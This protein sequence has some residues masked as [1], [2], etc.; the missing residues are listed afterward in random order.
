MGTKL[1][2]ATAAVVLLFSFT[3]SA[4][5][6]ERT[7]SRTLF[8]QGV[9][10]L[11]DTRPADALRLFLKAY[12]L[13]PHWSTLINVAICHRALGRHADAANVF[14]QVLD[15]TGTTSVPPEERARV[16]RLLAEMD[17]R[18][19]IVTLRLDPAGPSFLDGRAVEREPLRLEPGSHVLT[20]TQPGYRPAR[21]AFVVAAG[22]R[23]TVEMHLE[24]TASP[25]S[26]EVARVPKA[27]SADGSPARFNATFLTACGVSVFAFA[28]AT[29]TGLMALSEHRT[30]E[31]PR[32]SED[33]A[34]AARE[35]GTQLSTIADVSLIVGVAAAAFAVVVAVRPIT[36]NVRLDFQM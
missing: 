24:P 5:E 14:Q 12:E 36:K 20:S 16:Q 17:A 11:D 19:G 9:A 1:R 4:G 13:Y 28:S 30:Y 15:D 10:A 27:A 26:R 21:L 35:R 29:A 31:N 2:A 33:D 23:K 8:V 25:G 18:T 3:A 32:A 34:M 22:E 7:E 6:A